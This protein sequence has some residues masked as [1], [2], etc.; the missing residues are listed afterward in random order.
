MDPSAAIAA[1]SALGNVAGAVISS[2]ET[3]R[4]SERNEA[5]QM[6]FAKE[7]IRWKVEDAKRAGISP[8]YALG[9]S[10]MSFSPTHTASNAGDLVA[11]AGQ[12]I[13]RAALATSTKAERDL[14]AQL[15]VQTLRGMTLDNDIKQS[16]MSSINKPGNPPFPSMTGNKIPGQSQSP[17]EDVKLLRTGIGS[18]DTYSE[19]ASIPA[20]GWS[21]TNDGGL[22]PVPSQDVKQRIEDQLIPEAV[23][24]TQNM[25]APN[26]GKGNPPPKSALPKGA[27]GW[28]WSQSRQAYYPQYNKPTRFQNTN[29]AAGWQHLRN[30]TGRKYQKGGPMARRR[31]RKR[32]SRSFRKTTSNRIFAKRYKRMIT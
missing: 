3:R 16:Q 27:A 12:N 2:R 7:G 26:Y 29:E 8:E 9:A 22:R 19:A 13:A 24:A 6:R 25:I 15:K 10:T 5:M 21:E 11:D 18:K 20:V 31:Q 4:A 23:W 30:K 1:G 14:D 32:R 17:V 28:R